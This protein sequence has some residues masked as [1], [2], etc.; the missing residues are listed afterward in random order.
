MQ[1]QIGLALLLASLV[2]LT[3]CRNAVYSAYEKF[4][5]HKRDLLKK[6]VVQARDDQQEAGEQFKDAL[7]RLKEL[8]G[9]HGGNIE[10]TYNALKRD[11][12]RSSAKAEAVRER[13]KNVETIAADLFAEWERE[14]KDISAPDLRARSRD[15]LLRTRE[16]YDDLH[17]ALKR[18]ERSMEP[19]ITQFQ[20]HVLYLK[21]NL[22][23]E[24]IGAL[25]GE[26]LSIQSEIN[27][28]LEEMNRSI[29]QADKFI[30]ELP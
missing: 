14:I 11:F 18:A 2:T 21:H 7:T 20:D 8:Y 9:F 10:T 19:V 22:N 15:Q 25:K 30:K 6:A 4:G 1:I 5:V 24:A 3:G 27:K 16:R 28:L 26:S 17:A 23:A 13:V 29:A 12:D